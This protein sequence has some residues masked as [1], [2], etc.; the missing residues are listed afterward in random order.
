METY[1]LTELLKKMFK[2]T[3]TLFYWGN[4]KLTIIDRQSICNRYLNNFFKKIELAEYVYSYLEVIQY[5]IDMSSSEYIALLTEYA[6]K[7]IKKI[8]ELPENLLIKFYVDESTLID[9][10]RSGNMKE[11]LKWVYSPI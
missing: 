11:F 5:K 4:N 10:F 9:K 6:E 8:D 1:E 2:L 3:N 7:K